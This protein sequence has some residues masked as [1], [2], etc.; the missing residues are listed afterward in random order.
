MRRR[1]VIAQGRRYVSL[2]TG[3]FWAANRTAAK[4]RDKFV[5]AHLCKAF[6][7]RREGERRWL[8]RRLVGWFG[9]HVVRADIKTVI[10]AEDAIAH[11]AGQVFGNCLVRRQ[12]DREIGNASAGIEDIWLH[13]GAGGTGPDA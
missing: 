11:L 6:Q 12:F 9:V 1:R 3:V 5:R 10:A 7:S 8:E 13:D 2:K 4:R